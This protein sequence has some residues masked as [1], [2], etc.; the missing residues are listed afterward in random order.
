LFKAADAHVQANLS[1]TQVLNQMM[2]TI[3]LLCKIYYSLICQDLPEFLEDN[4]TEFMTLIH[5][6]LVFSP[7]GMQDE[8]MEKIKTII[9][10]IIEDYAKRYE[11]IFTQLPQFVGSVWTLL[12]TTSLDQSNDMVSWS[13]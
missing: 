13:Y 7:E 1:N 3:L 4:Q 2:P 12:T 11:E 5:R 8:V 9:C 6:Y 10:E